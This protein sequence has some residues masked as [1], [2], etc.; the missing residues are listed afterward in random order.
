MNAPPRPTMTALPRSAA[1]SITSR[2]NAARR[3]SCPGTAASPAAS[4][5]MT[6][7][8]AAVRAIPSRVSQEGARSSS[9]LEDD[10]AVEV[11]GVEAPGE[12]PADRGSAGPELARQ[13]NDRHV[14]S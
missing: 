9:R 8:Y 6:S 13:G 12:Q 7:G 2:V 3:S 1:S 4:G 14:E 11:L 5:T 10:L